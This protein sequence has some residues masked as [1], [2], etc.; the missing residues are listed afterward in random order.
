MESLITSPC[1]GG[2]RHANSP[3]ISNAAEIADLDQSPPR[4][5][6]PRA[7]ARGRRPHAV[8]HRHL[9]AGL[10]R[11][12]LCPRSD[13]VPRPERADQLRLAANLRTGAVGQPGHELTA[14]ASSEDDAVR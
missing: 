12:A 1:L 7:A 5:A 11:E 8:T 6:G 4:C 13:R 2:N 3:R 9:R 14:F 10:D